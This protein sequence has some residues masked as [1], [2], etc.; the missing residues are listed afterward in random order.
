MK[1]Y[2]LWATLGLTACVAA[3]Q[4]DSQAAVAIATNACVDT[5]GQQPDF[6][7][8]N[9]HLSVID[10]DWVAWT[11]TPNRLDCDYIV[12]ISM[13]DRSAGIGCLICLPDAP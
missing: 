9:W 7:V 6:G 10:T 11:G 2:I 5:F 4:T 3:P 1:R 8:D 12:Q 13:T